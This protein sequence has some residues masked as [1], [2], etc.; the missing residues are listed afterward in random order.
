[1]KHFPALIVILAFAML[2]GVTTYKVYTTYQ[3]GVKAEDE[4]RSYVSWIAFCAERGYQSS[5]TTSAVLDEWLDSWTG[6]PEEEQALLC[7]GIEEY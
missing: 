3:L 6:T 5:D 2:I 4:Q 1:M 7:A